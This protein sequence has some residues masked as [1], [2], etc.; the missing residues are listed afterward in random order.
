VVHN[1]ALNAPLWRHAR[2][3]AWND[4]D[5]LEVGNGG[6]SDTEYRAHF[7][8]WAEMA[9]PLIIGTDVRHMS[10]AT[11]RILTNREIVAVDQDRLGRQGHQVIRHG[12]QSVW[13]KPLAGGDVA[14][15]MLNEGDAPARLHA[16]LRRLGVPRASHYRVR[17]LWTHRTTRSAGTL[18]A[19]VDRHGVAM[20]RVSAGG[21]EDGPASSVSTTAATPYV[22]RGTATALTS[23]VT[24]DSGRALRGLTV[25]LATP[26]GWVAPGAQ[27]LADLAPGRTATVTWPV[28]PGR[29]A[30]W[31]TLR[32]TATFAGGRVGSSSTLDV[33]PAP[34]R[35]TSGLAGIPWAYGEMT[36]TGTLSSRPLR[37]RNAAG[38][39]M[40][41]NGHR[42]A[43]GIGVN[44]WSDVRYWLGGRCT[45]FTTDVGVDDVAPSSD[46][47]RGT[48][49]VRVLGDGRLLYSRFLD[50]TMPPAHLDLPV[51]GVDELRLE[52][53]ATRDWIWDDVTDWGRPRVSCAR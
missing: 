25:R 21:G 44:A 18:S 43:H 33:P 51:A 32:T 31:Q 28:Q 26:R 9:A 37:N 10:P 13:T 23:T 50:W 49:Q 36:P 40:K 35:G 20:F 6:L 45:R 8:L 52:V 19:G 46:T 27:R 5:M 41:V 11:R 22:P 29:H 15:L 48:V 7:S 17:N 47:L 1:A 38:K 12:A 42:Y 2:P 14:V 39:R 24:N 30:G 34:P 16:S 4:P 3:G 53:D